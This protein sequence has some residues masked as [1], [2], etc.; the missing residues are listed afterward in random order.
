M[1]A[2]NHRE[3]GFTLMEV[4]IGLFIMGV[5]A[6]LAW[7]GM[8]IL[9]RSHSTVLERSAQSKGEHDLVAQWVRDCETMVSSDE[10]D[11]LQKGLLPFVQGNQYFWWVRTHQSTN[12]WA[13]QI[14]G[15]RLADGEVQRWASEPLT[16]INEALGL[17]RGIYREPDLLPER[18][19][20][21]LSLGGIGSWQWNVIAAN[22]NNPSAPRSLRVVW[23]FANSSA[24]ITRACLAGVM[25]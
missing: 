12:R 5:V 20:K 4:L 15:Y 13:S 14:V 9:L 8:D 25:R 23:R 2:H 16:N 19:Q 17:W 3:A 18:V 22:P 1:K 6:V 11:A 21:S 10:I 24:S 7:R